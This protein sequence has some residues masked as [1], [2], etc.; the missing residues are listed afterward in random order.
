VQT[1]W[2]RRI[3]SAVLIGLTCF[4]AQADREK[5]GFDLSG[6]AVPARE[7]REGGPGRGGIPA[8]PRPSF[9]PAANATHIENGD[10]VIGVVIDRL[11]KAYPVKILNY[12]EIVNDRFGDTAVVITF[13]PLCGTGIA[14]LAEAGGMKRS[15]GVSGLLYNSDMLMYDFETE[16]LWSQIMAQAISGPAQGAKLQSLPARHTTWNDWKTRY[17]DSLVL[18]E[19]T[20]YGRNYNVDPYAGY[21][22]SKRVWFPVAHRDRRYPNKSVLIG[23]RIGA[24]AKAYP[25]EELDGDSNRLVDHVGGREIVVEYDIAAQAGRVLDSSERE[26]PSFTAYWFAWVA[27]HPESEVYTRP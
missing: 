19:P 5:N 27:F 4:S 23:V 3:L 25:F 24:T 9:I 17:P 2:S 21:A 6:A 11:S 22:D 7:I 18:E 15:F 12:H 16:S 8:L 1:A 20:K 26:I 13:C 14:F 10:R